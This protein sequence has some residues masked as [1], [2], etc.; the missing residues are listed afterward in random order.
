MSSALRDN[1]ISHF[2][3]QNS[4]V[5]IFTAVQLIIN[6]AVLYI[7][8]GCSNRFFKAYGLQFYRFPLSTNYVPGADPA[9][10]KGGIQVGK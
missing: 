8:V 6:A 5:I 3:H 7:A 10:L 2:E 9:I 1:S 4:F